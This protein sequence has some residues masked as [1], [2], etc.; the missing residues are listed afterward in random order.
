MGRR[1]S[2]RAHPAFYLIGGLVFLLAAVGVVLFA[3]GYRLDVA[4]RT[5]YK[6]GLVVL[7]SRPADA[8]VTL[9]DRLRTERTSARLALAPGSYSVK[10]DRP[11]T[12]PW[13]K[14]IDLSSGDAVLEEDILLFLEQPRERTINETPV[15]GYDL[16]GD[17][18]QVVYAPSPPAVAELRTY[19]LASGNT[20][21]V[22]P[23]PVGFAVSAI[24]AGSDD[25]RAI[26][27]GPGGVTVTGEGLTTPV[28]I[29]EA[30]SARFVPN[31][32]NQITVQ[33]GTTLVR[34]NLTDGSR[35]SVAEQVTA[36]TVTRAATYAVTG[37]QTVV[38]LDQGEDRPLLEGQP[39]T[40]LTPLGATDG[41]LARSPNRTLYL[42]TPAGT[43][44]I[45][46]DIDR[47]TA[48]PDGSVIALVS[49]GELTVWRQSDGNRRLVTRSATPFDDLAIVTDGHY[50]LYVQ[51]GQL[52]SIAVDGTND[53]TLL[54][55]GGPVRIGS[56]TTV[57]RPLPTGLVTNQILAE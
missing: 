46:E 51:S 39:I 40:D 35:Q 18:K 29:P 48:R 52:H 53:Q 12:R 5:F 7:K 42:L 57:I 17:L 43:R 45:A 10:V 3:L 8:F 11:G 55:V 9:N 47:F 49:R 56:D 26:A 14:R 27:I 23:L 30:T 4:E 50:L 2:Y 33:V 19:D 34:V 32:R 16:T 38:R 22:G 20:R 25:R 24:M 54:P 31:D 13:Q 6:T 28:V 15:S 36:W 41:V 1:Q 21:T 37:G 44:R